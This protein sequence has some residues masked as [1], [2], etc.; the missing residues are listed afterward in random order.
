[1]DFGESKYLPIIVFALCRSLQII[2]NEVSVV[3]RP[4]EVL[5]NSDLIR[6]AVSKGI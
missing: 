4:R 3:T 6:A 1:M 2:S 5:S